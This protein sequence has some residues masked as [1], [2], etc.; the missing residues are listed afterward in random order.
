MRIG[1]P[2]QPNID[3]SG[4]VTHACGETRGRLDDA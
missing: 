1:W 3:S 4:V 2:L